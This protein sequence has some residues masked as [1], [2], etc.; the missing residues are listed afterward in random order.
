LV[1]LPLAMKPISVIR[2]NPGGRAL[3]GDLRWIYAKSPVCTARANAGGT[4]FKV[5]P[6]LLATSAALLLLASIL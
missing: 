5:C 2:S 1:E 3:A 6:V 4:L